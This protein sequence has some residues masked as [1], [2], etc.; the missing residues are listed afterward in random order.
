M[1]VIVDAVVPEALNWVIL[2]AS[3]SALRGRG[4]ESYLVR[5]V[6]SGNEYHNKLVHYGGRTR[7]ISN[8]F[9]PVMPYTQ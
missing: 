3:R 8:V 9:Y 4:E 7:P 5:G 6:K 2:N 1:Q